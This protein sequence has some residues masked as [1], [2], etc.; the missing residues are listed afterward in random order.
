M[1]HPTALIWCAGL[2][3]LLNA[4]P[5]YYWAAGGDALLGSI[6]QWLIDLRADMPGLTGLAL[7]GIAL[8][9]TGAAVVPLVAARQLTS[10]RLI[11]RQLSSRRSTSHEPTSRQARWWNLSRLVAAGLIV[12]GAAG[13]LINAGLLLWPG[14]D[15][16]DPTARLGQALLW[17]PMLLLWGLVLAAGL[18]RLR[19]SVAA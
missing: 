15:L 17:Y 11:P 2:L 19:A 1:K 12:Y 3:G 6:G 13:L 18:R 8:G 4:A 7:L 10:R 14:L 16:Q 5:S 9:K